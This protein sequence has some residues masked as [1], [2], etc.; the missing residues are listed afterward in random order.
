[1]ELL[2]T[3]RRR[4]LFSEIV[5]IVLNVLL[6]LAIFAT[7]VIT[8]SPWYAFLLV[9][10]SKW[11][12]FAV[13]TRYWGANIRANMIDTV[14]GLSVV[15]FM[16]AATGSLPTQIGL[17]VLYI[18]WLLFIKPRSKRWF[19][20]AQAGVGLLFGIGAIMQ[21]SANWPASVVVLLTWLVGY[22]AA[23]HV[24]S[25]EHETHLNFL[26]LVWGFVVA[27][28]GWL[29]YHWT[30]GYNMP[31]SIQLAQA[32]IIIVLLSFLAERVHA[33]YQRDGKVQLQEVLLPT[34][35]SLSIIGILLFVFG[36]A[37]TI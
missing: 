28:I 26:S 1:M 21:L 35:L 31:G 16:F 12:V 5:Y 20:V 9:L 22:S 29:T 2:K 10:L 23:R 8:A 30:I 25:V 37:V 3:A 6:A 11:R 17:T 32:T 7:V 19:I 27:E 18:L 4:S 34:L 14:V 36:G 15:V 33:S 13:R 24:L